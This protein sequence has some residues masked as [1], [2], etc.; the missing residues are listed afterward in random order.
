M[1]ISG[2]LLLKELSRRAALSAA[3]T[4]SVAEDDRRA[5]VVRSLIRVFLPDILL[6]QALNLGRDVVFFLLLYT[7]SGIVE[8]QSQMGSQQQHQ[9]QAS[10][11]ISAQWRHLYLLL[12]LANSI[13]IV[14][15]ATLSVHAGF[16]TAVLSM[17]MK[18]SLVAGL[19]L[20]TLHVHRTNCPGGGPT[21]TTSSKVGD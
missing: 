3:S 18:Q 20:H 1:L 10:R 15:Y 2:D 21:P 9:A 17:R 7:T 11:I 4:S 5:A 6:V 14:L 8:L 16:R 13:C 12:F 19:F